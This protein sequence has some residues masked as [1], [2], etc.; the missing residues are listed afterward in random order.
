MVLSLLANLPLLPSAE[1]LFG[2][3]H[4]QISTSVHDPHQDAFQQGLVAL[5]EDKLDEALAKLSEAENERPS[6]ATIRNFRGI[7]LA[8]IGRSGEAASEYREAIRLDPQMED[9]HRNLG[10]LEWTERHLENARA[11]LQRALDLAPDD[12]FAHYYLG[13]VQLDAKLYSEAFRELERS[14]APWPSDVEFLMQAASGYSALGRQEEARKTAER[15]TSLPL[16]NAQSVSAAG[17]L[18]SLHANEAAVDLLRKTLARHPSGSDV[19]MQF[20]L[21]LGYLLIGNYQQ[22]AATAQGYLTSLKA[23]G[24]APSIAQ[25]W[26]VLGIAKAHLGEGASAVDAFRKATALDP[27]QEEHWLNLTRE[28]MDLGRFPEAISATQAGVAANPKS[29]A[30]HLRIGAAYLSADR[31]SQAEETFRQLVSAGD[32]LPTSYIGLA[33]VLLRTGRAADAVIELRAAEERLG[34]NFLISY[35]RGLA[36]NRAGKPEAAEGAFEEAA[37]LNPS[38]A[39][40]HL[41]LGKTRLALGRIQGAINELERSLSLSPGNVQAQRLLVQARRRSP[42][43]IDP[44]RPEDSIDEAP[45]APQAPLVDDFL[46]PEWV[47]PLTN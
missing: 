22:A 13:R 24:N 4:R 10:F 36:L 14:G 17:L 42:E 20:D 15:L 23:T 43:K 9:P 8:R 1:S 11:E 47:M 19:W 29:Y 40:A 5:K 44:S 31:Y 2:G 35:F 3:P 12:A 32:P 21:A 39:E 37:R 41:G 38:S 18:V 46:L 6:D 26:S 27:T 30:L 34:P 33:Q 45:A 28:L 16:S 7:V 25:G